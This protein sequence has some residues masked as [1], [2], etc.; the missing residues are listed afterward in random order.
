MVGIS[1]KLVT[2]F[3][4]AVV[5]QVI[6]LIF[7]L[8]RL[9]TAKRIVYDLGDLVNPRFYLSHPIFILLAVI[10]PL[11]FI[12]DLMVLSSVQ[13]VGVARLGAQSI[14]I[15][16]SIT[17]IFNLIQFLAVSLAFRSEKFDFADWLLIGCWVGLILLGSV[18]AFILVNRWST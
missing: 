3:S 13:A 15:F 17:V 2:A 6:F 16:Q 14:A 1:A 9:Y 7:T 12:G 4:W 10:A 8:V 11:V 5:V 18:I